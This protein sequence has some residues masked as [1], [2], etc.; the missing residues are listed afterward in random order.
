MIRTPFNLAGESPRQITLSAIVGRFC[1]PSRALDSNGLATA[2]ISRSRSVSDCV[3][4]FFRV[5][6]VA[7]YQ[8]GLLCLAF[9]VKLN[10]VHDGSQN[11]S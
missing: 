3:G 11:E 5:L 10:G 9:D 6:V 8:N 2:P 1:F 4:T 7:G